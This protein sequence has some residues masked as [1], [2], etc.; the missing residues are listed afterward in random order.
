MEKLYPLVGG[1]FGHGEWGRSYQ[2]PMYA[3]S[4]GTT[5]PLQ[6]PGDGVSRRFQ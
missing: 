5:I 4:D 6:T 3:P 2:C 1:V